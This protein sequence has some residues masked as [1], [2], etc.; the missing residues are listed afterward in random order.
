MATKGLAAR[1]LEPT[2]AFP[3]AIF[4]IAFG[5]LMLG[6]QLRFLLR[7]WVEDLYLTP[8]FHFTYDGFEWVQVLP[9]GWMYALVIGCAVMA[10]GI[11]LGWFYRICC[12]GFFLSFTYLELID[13]AWYL[14]HYYFVSL[15]AFLLIFVPAHRVWSVDAWRKKAAASPFVPAWSVWLLQFQLGVVYFFAGVAKIKYDWLILGEP[16]KTW[17]SARTDFPLIGLWF[18][19]P[20]MAYI[21]SW[22]GLI[23]D[24]SIPFFLLWSKTRPFAYLAVVGFHLMT[25]LLF[26]IGMFPWIMM[27][28]TLIFFT[29]DDWRKWGKNRLPEKPHTPPVFQAKKVWGLFLALYLGIQIFLPLRHFLYQGSVLWNEK[30]LRFAWHVMVMEKNGMTAYFLSDPATGKNWTIYPDAYLIPAQERQMA[31]QPDMIQQFGRFLRAEWKKKGYEEVRIR[32]ENR[33]CVNK[34]CRDVEWEIE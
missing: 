13:K 24:L 2:E 32:A 4:R 21:F 5:V 10:L 27:A 15:V 9:A 11:A 19:E 7:G 1:L 16:M 12:V 6:S 3:L 29:A 22:G 33:V 14:N 26:P 34:Q 18:D 23:Y 8:S 25:W 31:F 20:W 30:G 17:L 28:S